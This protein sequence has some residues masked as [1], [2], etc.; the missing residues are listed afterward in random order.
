MPVGW[1]DAEIYGPTVHSRDLALVTESDRRRVNLLVLG[2]ILMILLL[3]IQS[4][5]L[6]V[7]L[8]LTVLFS[9]YATLGATTLMAHLTA[10]RPLGE[11]DWRVPF[12]LFTIL[13][14]VGEDYN[15][16]LIVR[17]A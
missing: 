11:V 12:F 8:L 13:V 9:Y 17:A 1:I 16:L 14:A 10:G 15:I 7:Y 5:W 2:G 6:A 4:V 3:L